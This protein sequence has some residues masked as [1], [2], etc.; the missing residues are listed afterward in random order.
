M[1][2][3]CLVGRAARR[4]PS[5]GPCRERIRLTDAAHRVHEPRKSTP[6]QTA[7]L[8][9]FESTDHGLVHAAQLR[10]LALRE[11]E[12]LASTPDEATDAFEAAATA[13]VDGSEVE[14]IPRHSVIMTR[15]PHLGLIRDRL[16]AGA[17][18]LP[19]V[20]RV[21]CINAA[22]GAE[23]GEAT[24][25]EDGEATGAKDG[26]ATGAAGGQATEDSTATAGEDATATAGEDSTATAAEDATATARATKGRPTFA[27][28]RV[29]HPSGITSG[30]SRPPRT[31]VAGPRS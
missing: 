4:Q 12:S 29:M 17:D 22:T 30:T 19:I 9:G 16:I 6:S 3:P 15:T 5:G 24:G 7:Q 23:D 14:R 18:D 21:G 20:M 8:A 31:A 25:A 11:P 27:D 28:A 26:Q 2:G 1:D 10:E 13:S